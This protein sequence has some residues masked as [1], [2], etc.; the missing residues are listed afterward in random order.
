MVAQERGQL[1]LIG[2]IAVAIVVFST[3]LFA[4][5]LAVS[6]GIT[7]AG[8]AD[9]IERTAD[10]EASVERDLGRLAAKARGDDLDGF[11]ERYE[12]ALQNYTRTHNQVV[13]TRD[14]T[15][16]NATLNESASLGTEVNQ[17]SDGMIDDPNGPPTPYDWTVAEDVSRI[18]VFNFTFTDGHDRGT[19]FELTVEGANGNQWKL[20]VSLDISMNKKVTIR[21]NTPAP[22]TTVCSGPVDLEVDLIAGECKQGSS[23]R[24]FSDVVEPPYKISV[25]KGQKAEGTYRFAA[26]GDFP[27]TSYDPGDTTPYPVVPAVDTTYDTP[28]TSYNRTVLVEVDDG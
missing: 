17:T 13:G 21:D 20:E 27:S 8:S 22:P 28:S 15:Y 4:H 1:L 7:T 23:F 14:G 24:T 5:S 25:S 2:G 18:A 3:I 10:R 19:P 12:H 9:T 11:K 26:I 16:L 6:D